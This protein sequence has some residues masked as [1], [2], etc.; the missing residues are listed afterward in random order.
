MGVA[1][2]F[3]VQVGER[4]IPIPLIFTLPLLLLLDVLVLFGLTFYGAVKKDSRLVTIASGFWLSR[5]AIGLI[6]FGG[7]FNIRIR[8]GG[9]EVRIS[10]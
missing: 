9:S 1:L 6:L 4:R 7:G 3:T 10:G 8:D 2:W 5:L